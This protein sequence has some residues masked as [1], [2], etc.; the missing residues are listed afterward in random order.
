NDQPYCRRTLAGW[1]AREVVCRF[2]V[3]NQISVRL[4]NGELLTS[5]IGDCG[6][7]DL[8]N[9]GKV[10]VAEDADPTLILHRNCCMPCLLGFRWLH[11]HYSAALNGFAGEYIGLEI[12]RY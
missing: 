5:S 2:Q 9:L 11:I 6:S 8:R 7:C 1:S 10:P 12:M 3:A 4:R